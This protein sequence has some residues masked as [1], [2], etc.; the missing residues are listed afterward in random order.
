MQLT[1]YQI[2]VERLMSMPR[3]QDVGD[4]AANF[5]LD[6]VTVFLEAIGNPHKDLNC[7]H[8][9]G[10]NGK[11]TVCHALKSMY[12]EAGYRTALYTSPHLND[13]RE[14]FLIDGSRISEEDMV[15]FFD[16]FDVELNTHPLTFFELTTVIA[17][18]W[19]R[20]KKVDIAII[21]TGL[22]G[23]LDATNVVD[24]MV[25][26]ITSIGMDHMQQL[27]DTIAKITSEKAGIIKPGRPVVTGKLSPDSM[28]V[29]GEVVNRTGSVWNKVKGRI[30]TTST[31]SLLVEQD[32]GELQQVETDLSGPFTHINV[33]ICLIV[34]ELLDSKYPVSWEAFTKGMKKVRQNTGLMGRMERLSRDFQWFFDGAHNE[35]ALASILN[36]LKTK[37]PDIEPVLVMTMM[38][39]KFTPNIVSLLKPYGKIYFVD[40]G[41]PRALKNHDF[42][43]EIPHAQHLILTDQMDNLTL[44]IL[45]SSLVL[46]TGSFYFYSTVTGWMESLSLDS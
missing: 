17:F 44:N 7:V 40:M 36:H 19:F 28:A 3:F 2:V 32:D 13:V 22:G 1:P 6:Q 16:L 42:T 23:R 12:M 9:A 26:V 41:T 4:R 43:K 31:G 27:G 15:R 10:T 45:K 38:E 39:D 20:E 14:R 46:F 11:G 34:A 5:A 8:V 21:E 24:P 35:E 37:H 18:W 25:S 30:Q 33:E 29:I